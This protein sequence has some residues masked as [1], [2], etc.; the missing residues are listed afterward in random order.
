LGEEPLRDLRIHNALRVYDHPGGAGDESC[1]AFLFPYHKTGVTLAVVA[2]SDGG[3]DH[4]S[5]SLPN[6]CPNWPEMEYIRRQF[7]K[8]RECVVQIH[9]PLDEYVSG[10]E[11]G[12]PYCLH[13]WRDQQ[14][15]QRRPPRWMIGGAKPGQLLKEMAQ[16]EAMGHIIR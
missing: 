8:D 7:F 3:W 12:H 9:A 15:E 5:V 10:E 16:A 6:R 13:L 4:V 1:G 11:F 14:H 2:S